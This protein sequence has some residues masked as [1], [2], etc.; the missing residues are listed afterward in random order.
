MLTVKVINIARE[1]GAESLFFNIL[2]EIDDTYAIVL[3]GWKIHDNKI[4]P[5]A[6]RGKGNWYSTVL[7]N[8]GFCRLVQTAVE[9]TKTEG[10][11]LDP[12]AFVSAKWGQ[13]GLKSAAHTPEAALELWQRYRKGRSKCLEETSR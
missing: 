1:K 5:P 2:V 11:D 3:P 9:E 6:R 12:D 13:A 8:E 10:V 7:A 4:Y